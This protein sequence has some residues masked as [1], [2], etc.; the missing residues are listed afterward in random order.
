VNQPSTYPVSQLIAGALPPGLAA[1]LPLELVDLAIGGRSWRVLT[2]RDQDAL[3]DLADQLEHVPYGF[4]LWESAIALAELLTQH[5]E[6]VAGK[7]VLELGAGLGLP[8][9][10]AR[11]LGAEV[12]QTDHEPHALALAQIN[13]TQNSVEGLRHFLADWT[14]WEHTVQYDL[15]LGAD[16]LYER[17]MQ[18]HLAPIFARNLA[19]GGRLLLAD[20]SRPQA[21]TFVADLEK[22]GW[23][24][25]I[26]MQTISLPLVNR[27]ALLLG[28]PP[29]PT[30]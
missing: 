16:I 28:D 5:A 24:F 18:P 23:R 1:Q 6:W 15:I 17:A 20:P 7:R 22:Q 30:A 2:V 8:G 29:Q 4:L 9:L 3:L 11:S 14:A 19:P 21:L 12:W 10:V 27:T 25:E 13:A 26:T